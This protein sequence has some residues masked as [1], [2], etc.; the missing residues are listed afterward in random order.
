MPKQ[1]AQRQR[2][3]DNS[4]QLGPFIDAPTDDQDAS[5]C[6]PARNAAD[7]LGFLTVRAHGKYR[8][9]RW[10]VDLKARRY[11]FQI[12]GNAMS[13][14]VKQSGVLHHARILSQ[15]L[16][17]CLQTSLGGGIRKHVGLYRDDSV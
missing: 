14:A 5:I 9:L 10:A 6:E 13:V 1:Q 17:D 2:L 15:Q 4:G 7:S 11:A 12:A 8:R 16:V 3:S